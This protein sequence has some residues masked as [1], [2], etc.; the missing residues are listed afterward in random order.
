[1]VGR[2]GGEGCELTDA[3]DGGRLRI[4]SLWRRHLRGDRCLGIAVKLGLYYDHRGIS[5]TSRGRENI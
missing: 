2:E 4:E 3:P 5:E 1:M